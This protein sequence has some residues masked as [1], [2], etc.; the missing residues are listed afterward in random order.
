MANFFDSYRSEAEL[1]EFIIRNNPSAVRQKLAEKFVY[2][3]YSKATTN[4]LVREVT[5]LY[6]QGYDVSE[7]LNV[8]VLNAQEIVPEYFEAAELKGTAPKW[9]EVALGILGGL[10]AGSI[11]GNV[12]FPNQTGAPAQP[13]PEQYREPTF[14]Q[15]YG[16]TIII[17][18]AVLIGIILLYV[19]FRKK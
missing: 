4:D 11:I 10:V 15:R 19:L 16:N 13:L 14:W 18:A 7:L 1:I 5:T 8:E 17:S 9:Q 12:L 2:R 3:D 6:R